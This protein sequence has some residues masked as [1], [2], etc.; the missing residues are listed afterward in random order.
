[1]L[2]K[3]AISDDGQPYGVFEKSGQKL[4]AL[5][6]PVVRNATG[7]IEVEKIK[8]VET[9]RRSSSEEEVDGS[10]CS[11]LGLSP[12]F[13]MYDQSRKVARGYFVTRQGV[14][15]RRWIVDDEILCM[16]DED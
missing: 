4:I 6:E 5:V 12:A 7:G 13:S 2:V 3:S 11:F 16:T 1:M 10:D 8:R 9:T 14:E 15:Q